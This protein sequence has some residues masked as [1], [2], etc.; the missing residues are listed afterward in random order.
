VTALEVCLRLFLHWLAERHD[1]AYAVESLEAPAP[2][3]LSAEASDGER[4]L[5]L[6]V[7]DLLEPV[8]SPVW[9]AYREQMEGEIGSGLD[10][11]FALWLP[12]GADLP[13]G[14][15]ASAFV[16][17]VREA[18]AGLSPGERAQ[19]ALPA[20][21][22][23]RRSQDEGALMSVSGGLNRYWA[24]L[25]EK[26]RGSYDL[27]STE[28]HRLPESD[29]HLE[30]LFEAIW[31]RAAALAQ[32][33][34]TAEIETFDAWTLQ[35]LRDGQGLTIVGRPPDETGDVGLSVRRNF[36]RI[37]ADAVPRLRSRD[38]AARALVILGPYGRME[39]E[40]ATVAMR[41]YDPT[42][43]AGLDY[44]CLAADGLVKP[45]IEPRAG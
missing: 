5:A 32:V 9:L 16:E 2:D 36:R 18:A 25:S 21:L 11:A 10:G 27:D 33:G 40:G 29:E 42:L 38:A 31:A 20:T 24:R 19:V 3:A 35:R 37:L 44:V 7:R 13:Q 1:S 26:A 15:G 34:Q 22:R 28:V 14:D 39:D 6:E 30:T 23:L 45:L 17:R 12:P 41:G 43:Y 4:R 8:A